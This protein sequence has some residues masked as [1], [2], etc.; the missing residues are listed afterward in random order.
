MIGLRD[1]FR[2]GVDRASIRQQFKPEMCLDVTRAAAFAVELE[3]YV[4]QELLDSTGSLASALLSLH[5]HQEF[6]G[7]VGDS[8]RHFE[9]FRIYS[10][11]H[12]RFLLAQSNPAR[13]NRVSASGRADPPNSLHLNESRGPFCFLCECHQKWQHRGLQM[14]YRR[15][16]AGLPFRFCCNPFP[17][18]QYH[19]TVMSD[20]HGPQQWTDRD[21]LERMLTVML[22][23]GSQL[24]GWVL[25]YNGVGAGATIP[26]HRHFHL[27]KIESSQQ[28]FP[29]Q[30][31][32]AEKANGAGN[33]SAL[34]IVGG[35]DYPLTANSSDGCPAPY[36]C[37]SAPICPDLARATS[38]RGHREHSCCEGGFGTLPI[39]CSS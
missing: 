38:K 9:R 36:P 39:L 32:A 7:F 17:F 18:G 25:L 23:L 22:D 10:R 14:A 28:P 1:Q 2:L 29:L 35:Q 33:V 3:Q 27:V 13:A 30:H 19:T 8:L 12:A 21:D 5:A 24:P 20:T 26:H 15:R 4:I 37:T 6:K 11:D 31:A 34:P 16:L